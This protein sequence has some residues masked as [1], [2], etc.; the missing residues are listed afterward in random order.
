MNDGF[1]LG[2]V[3]YGRAFAFALAAI[4]IAVLAGYVG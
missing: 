1:S 4:A 3:Y 2:R